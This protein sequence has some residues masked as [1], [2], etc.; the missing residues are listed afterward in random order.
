MTGDNAPQHKPTRRELM[1]PAQLLS[2]AFAA[3]L[4]GGIVTLVAMGF[5][6][7][8]GGDQVPRALTAALVVA[9]IVFIVTLVVLALLM[10]AIDPADV[11]KTIDRPVLL[12]PEKPDEKPPAG[13]PPT[14][15]GSS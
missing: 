10:L 15:A 13:G 2:L 12:P 7:Q 8:R 4:F 14:G 11:T 9:G 6:Q 1:R 5:F 3:A